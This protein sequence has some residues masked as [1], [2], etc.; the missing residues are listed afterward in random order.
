[1][2]GNYEPTKLNREECGFTWVNMVNIIPV[3]PFPYVGHGHHSK[4]VKQQYNCFET[5]KPKSALK[6]HM[7]MVST[8]LKIDIQNTK[9]RKTSR[10][11]DAT[12]YK[13]QNCKIERESKISCGSG[14][15]SVSKRLR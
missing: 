14:Y 8:N 9:N 6:V 13:T 12:N 1:M 3:F 10:L 11:L 5:N 2:K 4:L 15:K 7:E